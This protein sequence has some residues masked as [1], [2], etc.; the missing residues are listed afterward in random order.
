MN[1]KE[2]ISHRSFIKVALYAFLFCFVASFAHA[3]PIKK[4]GIIKSIDVSTQTMV[5]DRKQ[6][7]TPLKW[8]SETRLKSP[9]VSSIED[10]KPGMFVLNFLR[11]DG[12]TISS[13]RHQPENDRAPG[14]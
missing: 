5:L 6:G 13:I 14:E 11:E 3:G 10:L 9:S 2:I 12:E 4:R 8:D 1:A 7:D